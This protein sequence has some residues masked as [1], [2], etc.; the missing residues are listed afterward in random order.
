M[1]K[2]FDKLNLEKGMYQEAAKKKKSFTQIL[3]EN[4]PSGQYKGTEHEGLDAF[5]R[6]LKRYGI[7]TAGNSSDVVEK[8][9]QTYESTLLFPEYIDRAIREGMEEGNILKDIVGSSTKIDAMQ[10]TAIYADEIKDED[11]E[12]DDIAEAAEFPETTITLRNQNTKFYK[13]GR[14]LKISYEAMKLMQIDMFALHLRKIGVGIGRQQLRDALHVLIYGDGNKNAAKVLTLGDGV[15]GG[16]SGNLTYNEI[17]KFY[18]EFAQGYDINTALAPKDVLTKILLM[19]EFKDPQA[20]FNYQKT[21]EMVNPLGSKW[22]RADVLA[23]GTI[24]GLDK[25]YCLE[26][27]TVSNTMIEYDK[28]INRQVERAAISEIKG[29]NKIYA[30][31]AKILKLK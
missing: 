1:D 19:E 24:I 16:V 17:V 30:D 22:L 23:E 21:G 28:I 6:Q 7:R 15:I 5:Q 13:R 9:Y 26:E 31:S 4:D 29:F 10:Y 27:V 11:I 25:K 20:G 14:L 12:L 2:T 18:M 3:E 8:F